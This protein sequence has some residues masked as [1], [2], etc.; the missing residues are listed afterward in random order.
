ME[1]AEGV[2][3]C[4]LEIDR[5]LGKVEIR[6]SKATYLQILVQILGRVKTKSRECVRIV[7]F[8]GCFNSFNSY[9]TMF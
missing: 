9:G 5:S 3:V 8:L 4:M 1:D 2:L 7:S 6:I